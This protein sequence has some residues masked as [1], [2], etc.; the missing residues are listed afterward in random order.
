[1][2]TIVER[3]VTFAAVVGICIFLAGCSFASMTNYVYE[4]GDQYTAGDREISGTVAT[5]DIDY[6][7]GDVTVVEA[8]TDHISIRETSK[9][10]L[11]DERKVHTWLDGSTLYVRYCASAKGL[12]L[13]NLDKKLT[14]EIPRDMELDCFKAELS[15]GDIEAS[16]AAKDIRVEASSGN[17]RMDQHGNSENIRLE[18]SSGNVGLNAESADKAELTASS[19]NIT[20]KADSIVTFKSESSS[21]DGDISF[22]KLPEM[23]DIRATSGDVTIFI[24]KDAD[25]TAQITTSSGDLYSEIGFSKNNENYV[26]GNGTNRMK[27]ETSSGNVYMKTLSE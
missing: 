12:D 8:D 21:G 15:S 1:M 19:G 10:P 7:S 5:I 2:K 22:I 4:N 13:S 3:I 27:V 16:C 11:D 9:K 26:C 17:I 24:P 20:V 6:L 14:I 25:L 23:S 18:A